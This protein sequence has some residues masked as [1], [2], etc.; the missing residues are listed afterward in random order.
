MTNYML[1]RLTKRSNAMMAHMLRIHI[2]FTPPKALLEGNDV[3]EVLEVLPR[4]TE[5]CKVRVPIP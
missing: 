3:E 2:N 4:V 5:T 1:Y